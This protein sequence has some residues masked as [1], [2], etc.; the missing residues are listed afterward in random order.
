M[1]ME[2]TSVVPKKEYLLLYQ[3]H[4]HDRFDLYAEKLAQ[5]HGWEIVRIGFGRADKEKVGQSLL[6]ISVEQFLGLFIHAACVLTDSFHA[7]AFS[8]NLGTDFISILPEQFGTRIESITQLTGTEDRVLRSMDDFSVTNNKID[9]QYV[10]RVLDERREC[11][12]DFL[13]RSLGL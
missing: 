12:Y 4:D 13:K 8:L 3:L 9:T 10:E 7:T 5:L 2:D 11:G 6:G 1:K